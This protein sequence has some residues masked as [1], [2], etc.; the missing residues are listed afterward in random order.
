MRIL[1]TLFVNYFPS[2]LFRG[3]MQ[4]MQCKKSYNYLIK[5]VSVFLRSEWDRS[6]T[7]M[8]DTFCSLK[9]THAPPVRCDGWLSVE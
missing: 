4:Y 2:K 6:V 5:V 9:T 7:E 1:F 8:Q 3:I